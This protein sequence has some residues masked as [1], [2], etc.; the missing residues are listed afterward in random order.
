MCVCVCVFMRV[1]VCVCMSVCV[2][3]CMCVCVCAR[4]HPC[5]YVYV[6]LQEL[7][8]LDT[9]LISHTIHSSFSILHT[10]CTIYIK[11]QRLKPQLHHLW[12]W[13]LIFS[14]TLWHSCNSWNVQYQLCT[15][16]YK[17]L[18]TLHI[19]PIGATGILMFDNLARMASVQ[20]PTIC[21]MPW[22]MWANFFCFRIGFWNEIIVKSPHNDMAYCIKF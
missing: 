22:C 8:C 10:Y 15:C 3:V 18:F 6:E 5:V 19:V 21:V 9:A 16:I 11:A 2:C 13:L 17:V 12:Q 4:V 7:K 1:Y 20:N 14:A